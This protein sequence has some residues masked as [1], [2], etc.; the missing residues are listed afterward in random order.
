MIREYKK[1]FKKLADG[2]ISIMDYDKEL[3]ILRKKWFSK[4]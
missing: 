4:K 1:L 2:K 3:L